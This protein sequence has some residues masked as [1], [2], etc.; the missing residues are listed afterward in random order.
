MGRGQV[1][2]PT[3]G[4]ATRC[5]WVPAP[6]TRLHLCLILILGGGGE[7]YH[8]SVSGIPVLLNFRRDKIPQEKQLEGFA[9]YRTSF[10]DS[11]RHQEVEQ[12]ICYSQ[13]D[14]ARGQYA[15]AMD[16]ANTGKILLPELLC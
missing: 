4:S 5:S 15:C 6:S 13:A 8:L 11:A 14:S 12:R 2:G 10:H 1:E 16:K 9:N 3:A 7:M